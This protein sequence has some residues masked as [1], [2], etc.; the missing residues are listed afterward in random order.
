MGTYDAWITSPSIIVLGTYVLSIGLAGSVGSSCW[1][2]WASSIISHR[3]VAK[4][5]D[6]GIIDTGAWWKCGFSYIRD[7]ETALPVSPLF[8]CQFNDE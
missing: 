2:R 8:E 1:S 6:S 3:M 5:Q 4:E 7:K